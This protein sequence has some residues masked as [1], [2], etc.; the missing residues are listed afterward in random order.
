MTTSLLS[1]IL[2]YFQEDYRKAEFSISLCF[3][4]S[5]LFSWFVL[6]RILTI[7]NCKG[8][9]DDPDARKCHTAKVPR[10]G[11]LVFIPAVL[12]SLSF[13]IAIRYLINCPLSSQH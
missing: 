6:P 10:L 5:L 3:I 8:L 1:A 12:I 4:L 13:T 2:T 11:G 7:A 9:Y